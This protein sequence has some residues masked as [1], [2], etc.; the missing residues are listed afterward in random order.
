MEKKEKIIEVAMLIFFVLIPLLGAINIINPWLGDINL[1]DEGQFAAWANHMLHGKLMYK[2]IYITYGPLYVYPLY[3]IFKYLGTE[4]I[5]IRIFYL[6]IGTSFGLI[7]TYYFLKKLNLTPKVFYPLIIFLLLIPGLSLRQGIVIFSLLSIFNMVIKKTNL[8]TILTGISIALSFL[9]S[10]ES[11]ILGSSVLFAVM[12]YLFCFSKSIIKTFSEFLNIVLGMLVIFIPFLIWSFQEGWL[13]SYIT[14]TLD[15]AQSFSGTDLPNGKG[16]P[17]IYTTLKDSQST[18]ALLKL[19]FSKDVMLYSEFFIFAVSFV[20]LFYK[21][22][23]RKFDLKDFAILLIVTAGFLQYYSL[24]GRSGNFFLALTPVVIILAF[25]TD[26]I[27]ANKKIFGKKS[28]LLFFCFVTLLY[29]R[30]V[31]IFWPSILSLRNLNAHEP[32][33]DRVGDIAITKNQYNY[34]KSIKEYVINNTSESDFVFFLSN[35]PFLYYLTDRVNPTRFDLPYIAHTKEK[36][37]EMLR[38]LE[39]HKP[40]LIF[41]DTASWP[42]DEVDNKKRLPEIVNFISKHYKK[43]TLDKGRVEVYILK[44]EK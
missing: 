38:D 14:S 32:T 13:S 17:N 26:K 16:F 44:D 10:F 39:N 42:V 37:F 33:I 7:A 25:F 12:I 29:M 24:V 31:Y 22:V 43:K 2:D 19:P 35:E 11:G 34:L 6:S 15:V 20:Y 40:K 18:L 1:I 3:L 8:W 36:R 5:F 23:V 21:G 27:A 9:I 28:R 4:F 30:V 41:Y